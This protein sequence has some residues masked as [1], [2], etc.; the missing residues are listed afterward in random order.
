L[1]FF[2]LT[3]TYRKYIFDV[4]DEI[5]WWGEGRYNWDEIYNMPLWLRRFTFNK[6]KE[7]FEKDKKTTEEQLKNLP[8]SN[9]NPNIFKPKNFNP[10]YK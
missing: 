7:R 5:V 2:G 8:K 10:K 6:L 9:Q 4:I 3:L 1:T